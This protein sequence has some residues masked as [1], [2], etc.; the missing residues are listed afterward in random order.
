MRI[1]LVGCPTLA[2]KDA[3]RFAERY[4]V[5]ILGMDKKLVLVTV[6]EDILGRQ[7]RNAARK[8][9]ARTKTLSKARHS[10]QHDSSS[11]VIGQMLW[12]CDKFIALDDGHLGLSSIMQEI[13]CRMR[14]PINLVSILKH[15]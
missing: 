9:G 6:R 13:C 4:V 5:E 15:G 3:K 10:D 7:I 12:V 1:G 11:L 8:F 14:K 2:R